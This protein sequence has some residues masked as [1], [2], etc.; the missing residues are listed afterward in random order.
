MAAKG[1]RSAASCGL[2]LTVGHNN[3]VPAKAIVRHGMLCRGRVNR[4]TACLVDLPAAIL[5]ELL[6]DA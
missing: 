1:F 6:R 3:R 2:R 5:L 4:D